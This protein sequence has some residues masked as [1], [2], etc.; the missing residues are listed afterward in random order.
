MCNLSYPSLKLSGIPFSLPTYWP[1]LLPPLAAV[2]AS[3]DVSFLPHL[4]C[5]PPMPALRTS[6]LSGIVLVKLYIG[7][8]TGTVSD[9][10]F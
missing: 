9:K 5:C 7:T 6:I 4:L 1:F 8:S 2:V 10:A 3:P